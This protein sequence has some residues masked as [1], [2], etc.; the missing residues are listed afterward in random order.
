MQRKTRIL[1]FLAACVCV[2][3]ACKSSVPVPAAA[4]SASL[5]ISPEEPEPPGPQ[6]KRIEDIVG[7]VKINS[8]K[9]KKYFLIREDSD[10]R[11]QA[12]FEGF[13]IIYDLDAPSP[14]GGSSF[15]VSFSVEDKL[16][17]EKRAGDFVWVLQEDSSGIALAFD[18]DP[19]TWPAYFD[20]LDA[21]GARVTFFVNG[22]MIPFCGQAWKRGHDIGCHTV[23]HRDLRK[24]SREVFF[25]ETTFALDGFRKAEIDITAFAYPYGFWKDWMHG[26]LLKFYRIVRGFGVTFRLYNSRTIREGYISSKSID[27]LFY[28]TDEEFEYKIKKMLAVTKFIGEGSIVTFTTHGISDTA[29]WGIKP[30][31]LEFL[32]RT[33]NELKLN[34]YRY[35]DFFTAP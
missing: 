26:E 32:L 34:F 9:I 17:G 24:V 23:N 14:L 11:V 19:A 29:Q 6:G 35:R 22:G 33:G 15:E 28:K 7:Y 13:E 3:I 12:D 8:E 31:R 27:N 20:M 21:Y 25:Y 4:A 1:F 10:L 18:D 16:T 2:I 30:R 5:Y